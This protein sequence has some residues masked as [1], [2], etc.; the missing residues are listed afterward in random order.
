MGRESTVLEALC[1]RVFTLDETC[2]RQIKLV[3]LSW[4]MVRCTMS[5]K[6]KDRFQPV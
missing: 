6:R 1:R 3:E 4:H 2:I 5:R